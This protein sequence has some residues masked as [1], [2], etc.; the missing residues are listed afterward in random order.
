MELL[1]AAGF[2]QALLLALYFFQRW[3]TPGGIYEALMLCTLAGTI[4]IGLLYANGAI[5][6][7]PQLARL[8][9][10]GGALLGP[11][12]YFSLRARTRCSN[13]LRRTDLTLL[14]VPLGI[15]LYLL[16]FHLS[17]REVKLQ[18]LRE[19]LQQV[20]LDCI[21][22][23]YISLVNNLAA[24]GVALYLSWS[25]NDSILREAGNRRWTANLLFHALPALVILV[26]AAL[27][28]A[29][30]NWLNAGLFSA[31]GALLAMSRSYLL[32]YQQRSGWEGDAIFPPAARYQKA[33][34]SEDF[35]GQKGR[36]IDDYLDNEEPYLEP[37]FQLS[38]VASRLKLS[39]VQTSQI[40]NRYFQ[41]SFLR[42]L[43]ER[44]VARAQQLLQSRPAAFSI[45]DVALESGFN[46]KSA[47]NAA[48]RKIAGQSPGEYRAARQTQ[49]QSRST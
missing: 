11:L 14:I 33:L 1:H 17:P 44:R 29:D 27:S 16:P 12:L 46:S 7:Y 10:S 31:A 38:D 39:A 18:Y 28:V 25:T 43:Q 34:L 30:L 8:G 4:A 45:L 49:S 20:H 2:A 35:V 19:D 41:R 32:L 24:I 36:L 3:R 6:Q 15:F 48:F 22:I 9:F 47:F 5:L 23:L 13:W 26:A 37:D 40:I 42:L 21:V